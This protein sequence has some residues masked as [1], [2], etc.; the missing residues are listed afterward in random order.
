MID[1]ILCKFG[2]L[3]KNTNEFVSMLVYDLGVI[4]LIFSHSYFTITCN[5]PNLIFSWLKF[6]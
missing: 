6:N 2:M 4:D 1:Y 3:D 5:Y